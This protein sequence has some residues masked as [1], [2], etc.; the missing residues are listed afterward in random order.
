[1]ASVVSCLLPFQIASGESATQEISV[2]GAKLNIGMTKA[3]AFSPFNTYHT[4]CIGDSGLPPEC[5]S[6][7]IQSNGP[8]YTPYANLYFKEGKLKHVWKY[9]ERGFEGTQPSKFAETLHAILSQ[10]SGAEMTVQTKEQVEK[11][12]TQRAIFITKGHRTVVINTT[13]GAKNAVGEPVASFVNLYEI[14]E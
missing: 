13:D 3:T 11:G 10:Y 5:D 4:T 9:W 12:V 14:L 8:P 1:M 2:L 6:W 7:L